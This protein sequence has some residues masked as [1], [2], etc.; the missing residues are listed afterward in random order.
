MGRLT[1]A[2]IHVG[3]LRVEAKKEQGCLV[4]KAGAAGAGAARHLLVFL[5][6]E[7]IV[8][9][10]VLHHLRRAVHPGPEIPLEEAS[11]SLEAPAARFQG[12]SAHV[13]RN[14]YLLAV[15]AGGRGVG[16]VAAGRTAA[17]RD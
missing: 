15:L 16:K 10:P 12:P 14:M 5:G 11:S 1:L 7:M 17:K 4:A 8:A 9:L 2:S 6:A 13:P 3:S